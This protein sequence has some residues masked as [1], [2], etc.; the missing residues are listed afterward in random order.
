MTSVQHTEFTVGPS[1]AQLAN[2]VLSRVR[3]IRDR[4]G[5]RKRPTHF[6]SGTKTGRSPNGMGLRPSFHIIEG[7]AA[8]AP[9]GGHHQWGEEG[10]PS[11]SVCLLRRHLDLLTDY[12]RDDICSLYTSSSHALA[13]TF[14]Q[15]QRPT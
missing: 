15:T 1:G 2:G 4:R 7:M 13:P 10:A 14:A 6:S 12:A 5:E 11:D 3:V 9:K 8:W